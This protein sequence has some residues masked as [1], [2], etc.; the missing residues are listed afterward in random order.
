MMDSGYTASV[1]L[2]AKQKEVSGWHRLGKHLRWHFFTVWRHNRAILRP[3]CGRSIALT[4]ST[5]RL[6][7]KGN[8]PATALLCMGCAASP[9][10]R[11]M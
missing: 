4:A 10:A 1:L 6:V 8:L 2:Y 9:K 3:E 11:E 5:A 7:E